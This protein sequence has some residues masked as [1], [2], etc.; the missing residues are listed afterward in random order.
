MVTSD[1]CCRLARSIC[2]QIRERLKQSHESFEAAMKHLQNHHSGRLEKKEE[3]RLK[4][5]KIHAPHVARLALKSISMK[6][7]IAHGTYG[8]VVMGLHRDRVEER[9]VT[10]HA[11]RVSGVVTLA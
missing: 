2:A 11:S 10:R 5:R 3:Q 7:Y 4:V 6:D 8:C 9:S 1:D